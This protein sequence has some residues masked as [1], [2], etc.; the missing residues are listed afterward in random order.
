MFASNM[1]ASTIKERIEKFRRRAEMGMSDEDCMNELSSIFGNIYSFPVESRTYPTGTQFFRARP[2]A[3]EDTRLPLNIIRKVDDAWEP[4][5][6]FVRTQGRLNRVGQ[7]VL[8]C[9]PGDPHTAIDE[10]R[11]RDR[12]RVALMVYRS[13]RPVQVAV[14]GD[15]AG[16]GLPMDGATRMFYE[17]LDQ[18]FARAVPSGQEARY[19]IT[20]AVAETF[21]TYPNQD[22]WCYRSVLSPTRFNTAFS[23]DRARSCLKLI[24]AMICRTEKTAHDLLKVD[25]V[26]GFDDMTAEPQYHLIGS[27]GQKEVFPEIT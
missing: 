15:Y 3:D 16:S 10:A 23:P 14:M 4:P 18:E 7:G 2:M 5:A 12:K 13:C 11:A 27:E 19:S 1:D 20:R 6:E 22:A 21:F 8:Y 26:V 9:C 24:G 25:A 17:F